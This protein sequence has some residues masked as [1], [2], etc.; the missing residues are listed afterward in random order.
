MGGADADYSKPRVQLPYFTSSVSQS[1]PAPTNDNF[2]PGT[3]E[4]GGLV[5]L[6]YLSRDR[7]PCTWATGRVDRHSVLVIRRDLES[8]LDA[9]ALG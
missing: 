4:A 9:N 8:W 5:Y 7:L 3:T 2:C 6:G 1:V